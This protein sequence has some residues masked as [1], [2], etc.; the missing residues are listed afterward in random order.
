MYRVKGIR[1]NQVVRDGR[2][3]FAKQSFA[4]YDYWKD[5]IYRDLTQN[6]TTILNLASAEYSKTVDK[7]LSANVDYVTCKFGELIGGKLIEKGVYVKMARGEMVR[8]MAENAVE[9]LDKI[10]EFN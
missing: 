5:D 4:E 8:F 6:E 10:K 9:D 3:R 7:Y 2:G 1:G